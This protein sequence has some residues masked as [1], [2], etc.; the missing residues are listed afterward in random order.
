MLISVIGL[1]Y[2]GLP[3]AAL[4]ASLRHHV[5]GIDVDPGIV[6]AINQGHI[7]IQEPE[8]DMLVRAAVHAGYLRASTKYELSDVFLIAV[9]TPL[10]NEK[11]PDLSY[12][13]N[14]ATALAP[15]LSK[16]N[17][18][19]LESTVPVGT[20]KRLSEFLAQARPDLSFPHQKGEDSDI[21]LAY[22][23]ERVLPGRIVH[24]L[25]HNDRI[26]GGLTP[27]CSQ[28]AA[29][30]YQLF[31]Q[32]QCIVT[33]AATAEMCKLAENT[34]RDVNIALA[35][36][37]SM[38][39]AD[40]GVDVWELVALANRHPRV[41]ILSP[42]CGVGG[43]CIAV[44][45]WFL[46]H[47]APDKT[48]LTQSARQVNYSKTSWV[49]DQ[50]K[51]VVQDL[52]AQTSPGSKVQVACL[53]LT[54]K[55]NVA[56]LRHSPALEIVHQLALSSGASLAIVE[57]Y[58]LELPPGL[59]LLGVQHLDIAEALDWAQVVVVL[60]GHKV[61]QHLRPRLKPEQKVIDLCGIWRKAYG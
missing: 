2:I 30:L 36:E 9:S 40:Q 49:V 53:G 16:G 43:H 28:S 5:L 14:V 50:V 10:T 19:I 41:N 20:T 22:C 47:G 11:E 58:V 46:V 60:V 48:R 23:P 31:A 21:R 24:E 54:F 61:F 3:T 6:S 37:L 51:A 12:V 52:E 55:A 8:L 59:A 13:R 1:G 35:N 56:D 26:I 44:D 15:I 27:K 45:P 34:Y 7:H 18:V 4:L 33:D 25:I 39:C 32:G 29:T 42:G 57:P 38:I 17:L